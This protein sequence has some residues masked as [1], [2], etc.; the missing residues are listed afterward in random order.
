VRG[1]RMPAIFYRAKDQPGDVEIGRGGGLP[2]SGLF[3]TGSYA[4]AARGGDKRIE[5]A[6]QTIP[7]RSKL[8]GVVSVKLRILL[9]ARKRS[10]RDVGPTGYLIE[11]AREEARSRQFRL[12]D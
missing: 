5:N 10:R 9:L 3:F 12:I 2:V 1:G 8:L 6:A 7:R 11:R 4:T